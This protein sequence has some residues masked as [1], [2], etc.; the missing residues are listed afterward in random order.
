MVNI[1]GQS[2]ETDSYHLKVCKENK[3]IINSAKTTIQTSKLRYIKLN[4][5]YCIRHVSDSC[6]VPKSSSS[7]GSR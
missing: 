1:V 6:N 5:S 7:S 3:S 2:M 4:R